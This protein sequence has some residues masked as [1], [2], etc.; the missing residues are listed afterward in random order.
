[1]SG[2]VTAENLLKEVLGQYRALG[3]LAKLK[4]MR[5]TR[6]GSVPW[7]VVAAQRGV[8]GLGRVWGRKI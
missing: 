1:M 6:H 4:G 5:G 3:L 7:H 8:K 2:R